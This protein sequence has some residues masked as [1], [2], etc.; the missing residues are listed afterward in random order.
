MKKL[1]KKEICSNTRG[2]LQKNNSLN[3]G[4]CDSVKNVE[5]V[6]ANVTIDK[7]VFGTTEWAS[8]TENFINGCRH[9]CKYCFAKEM[10]IRFKRKTPENWAI[11]EVNQKKAHKTFK[12]VDGYIM[13]PSSHDI[14]SE[15]LL[16]SICFLDNLLK[17]G[18]KVL[19]VTKPHLNV[20][21]KLCGRFS[22]QKENILF[23]FTIGSSNTR[24][25]K[26]WE[27]GAPSFE[28]RLKSLKLAYDLGFKTSVSCEPLLDSDPG[29]LI[30][31]LEPFITDA[32]WIGKPNFLI[33]RLKTNGVND[34]LSLKKADALIRIQSDAWVWS[35]FNKY[36]KNPMIKWKESFKK[37][38]GIEIPTEKGLDV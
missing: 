20:V 2:I 4:N 27:P 17:S 18:N 25:L 22:A 6:N 16:H 23:R 24:T 7:Q 8:K 5:P 35:I 37:V 13:F 12:K 19:I 14:S 1:S 38:V 33:K 21:E 28:E 15:N 26:F 34:A 11:E 30:G 32:I 10:A 3:S 36:K 29:P 9:D 31:K